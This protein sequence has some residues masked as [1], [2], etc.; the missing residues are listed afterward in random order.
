M[1]EQIFDRD[2]SQKIGKQIVLPLSRAIEISIKSLKIRFWRSIITV[3]SIILAIAFL[4]YILANTTMVRALKQGP[5]DDL[6]SL[7]HRQQELQNSPSGNAADELASLKQQIAQ[8]KQ[9]RDKLRVALQAEGGS[10]ETEAADAV[11]APQGTSAVGSFFS[12][13]KATDYW[14]ISLALLV[15]FVGIVNA[16]LMS[17]TERFREIGT[18]KCLGAL[19]SFIVKLFLLESVFQGALGTALGIAVGLLL[20]VVRSWALYGRPVFTYM[21]WGGLLLC[22]VLAQA[23]GTLLSMIAAV[24]PARAAAR[25]QPVEALRAEQ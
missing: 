2:V 3:S 4:A 19:D 5:E 9:I 25:M 16:M 14:L 24:F 18:M 7:M 21:P 8:K 13:M 22:A 12:E 1:A 23:V 20:A 10:D 17:V 6:Q 15:C 11:G